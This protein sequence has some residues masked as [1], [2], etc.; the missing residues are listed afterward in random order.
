MR[1]RLSRARFLGGLAP[2]SQTP[3][4]FEHYVDWTFGVAAVDGTTLRSSRPFRVE[5]RPAW[6]AEIVRARP[7][8][9]E[10]GVEGLTFE[11]AGAPKRPHNQE[12]GYNAIFFHDIVNS[13]VRDVTIVDADNGILFA[14]CGHCQV[15]RVRFRAAK[16]TTPSGHH[17]LWVK[18][19]QDC[20]LTDFRIETIFEHDLSVEGFANGNVFMRGSAVALSL[21]HH[22]NA[23]YENLFTDLDAGSGARLW[24]SGGD[25]ARGA[26]CW[27]A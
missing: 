7:T 2:G 25:E 13:W 20:L 21:D 5:V 15:E 22:R 6:H 11:F 12:E 26:T 23:P 10:V 1:R 18:E 8:V 14:G 9:E 16:R 24:T 17:A 19:S 4:D 27:R 3:K